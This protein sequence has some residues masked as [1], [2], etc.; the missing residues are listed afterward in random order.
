MV[1]SLK[2]KVGLQLLSGL[3]AVLVISQAVQFFQAKRSNR[4]LTGS[5]ETILQER[6]L[7]N[8]RNI[9]DAVE[10]GL[11]ECLARGDMQIFDRLVS[12]QKKMPDLIEFSLYNPDGKVTDSSTKSAKNRKLDPELRNQLFSKP[13]TLV[14]TSTNGI[15]IYKP[16]VATAKC[17]ECH[18]DCKVGAVRGVTYFRFSNA[19]SARL[20]KQFGAINA[21]C[22]REWKGF[23]AAL[24]AFGALMVGGL[25]FVI[26]QPV[27]KTLTRVVED[28]DAHSAEIRAA[29]AQV[30]T[31][32]NALA[33]TASEQAAASEQSA[34]AI[35]TIRDHAKDSSQLTTGA[36]EMMKENIRKSGDSLRAIVEMNRRMGQ[37]ES[38]SGEMGKI[39][40]SIDDIA[41]QTN[42]LALN[43][44]VEAARAGEA[45]AG[46]AVVAQEVR[47]LALHSAAAAKN[48]Q[49]LLDNMAQRIKQS[50][51]AI[52]EINDNFEAIV[53]TAS[54]MGDKIERIIANDRSTLTNLEQINTASTQN[55]DAAQQ[56]AAT[57]EET[58]A[59]SEELS[60]QAMEMRAVS[61]RLRALVQ[62]S[63]L[64]EDTAM[65]ALDDAPL[66]GTLV[67]P[68]APTIA[69][70][71]R[72]GP[73]QD[74]FRPEALGHVP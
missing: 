4:K 18:D 15:E 32:S 64:D 70:A 21:D 68:A 72:S 67:A 55:A 24:L 73:V 52:K 3:L 35:Q 1:M 33:S 31:S 5:G 47:A 16:Q 13:D 46:F 20:A 41:F 60:A 59:A 66:P 29:A 10:F 2:A 8:T 54:T 6:E 26:T 34:A 53:E 9:H 37:M 7:Q 61:V 57:S 42:L 62:G 38:D 14:L 23:S 45:G 58:S 50:S 40:K 51:V 36:T 48:T 43:A 56:V 17:L 22:D 27:L 11:S 65:A 71:S 69:R 44:A 63:A 30:G 28:L 39:I 25:T 74:A 49:T 12:L 19:S